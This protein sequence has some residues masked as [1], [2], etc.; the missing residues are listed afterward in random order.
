MK[1]HIAYILMLAAILPTSYLN[2][3]IRTRVGLPT[4]IFD[5]LWPLLAGIGGVW[6]YVRVKSHKKK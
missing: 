3:W 4:D 1:K 2:Y 6:L 5:V